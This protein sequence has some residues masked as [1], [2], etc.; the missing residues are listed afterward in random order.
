ML[1][2]FFS[3]LFLSFVIGCLVCEPLA[4]KEEWYLMDPE[5]RL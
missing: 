4:E 2:G 5:E 1:N 3:L